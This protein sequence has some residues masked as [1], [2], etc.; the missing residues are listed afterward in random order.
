M[1]IVIN[2]CFGGFGLSSEA[3]KELIERN[4]AAIETHAA[5]EFN[6]RREDV[7]SGYQMW[8]G[9]EDVLI[10]GDTAYT[11][12]NQ[13]RTDATLV[14][15]VEEWGSERTSSRLAKLKVVEI[16]DGTR[17]EIDEYDGIESI[18]ETHSIWS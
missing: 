13:K 8:S 1:K 5:S 15:L 11:F 2:K 4:C 7:G 16:P 3:M 17:Y 18:H 10:K 9:I 6:G 14:A 12:D